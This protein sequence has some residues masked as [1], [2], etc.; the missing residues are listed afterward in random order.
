MFVR[1]KSLLPIAWVTNLE[2]SSTGEP[3]VHISLAG[4]EGFRFAVDCMK[5]QHIRHLDL[6]LLG[7][8][9]QQICIEVALLPIPFDLQTGRTFT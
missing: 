6:S 8:L 4:R 9:L 1:G 7:E 2:K 3:L 5:Q